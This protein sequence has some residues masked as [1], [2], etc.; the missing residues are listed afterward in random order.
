MVTAS[1][2]G[3]D[4]HI[5]PAAAELQ[6]A[7]VARSARR[8]R[9]ARARARFAAHTEPPTFGFLG[10]ARVNVLEL[11]LALDEALGT[12]APAAQP[13]VEEHH[14]SERARTHF[15]LGS[16]HR[17]AGDRRLVPEARSAGADQEP[18]DVHRRGR[19]P[20]DDDR[21]RPGAGRRHRAAAVHRTG[22][23]LA[24]V[25]GALRQLR[26]GDGRRARQGAGGHAA[27]G[28]DRDDRRSALRR[29]RAPR[30]CRRRA[31]APATSCAS[32]PASSFPAT[33]R[34][35][36]ACASVDESAITGES[37][38]V[39]RESGGDRSAVTGGTRVLSDWI[40]VRDHV[41]IPGE[42]FLDRMIALVEGARA[43]E[44][45][46]RD[47]AEHPAGGADAGLPAGRRDAAA[48]R[49]LRRH[50]RS[51]FRC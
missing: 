28:E 41:R 42:T 39:I 11:N 38:P 9:R 30:R 24:V 29:R 22:R 12:P 27:Q 6:A 13:V 3:L 47:R 49:A 51:R 7:R 25:H 20:A 5:P 34:S 17:P 46:E 37:A 18:G 10:R 44:D 14:M 36:R 2:A 21:L 48:V 32:R 8:R 19:Q 33:A 15:D 40:V 50:R 1:G 35:S 4:P 23:V 31:C 26:R 16:G 45:A 43:A